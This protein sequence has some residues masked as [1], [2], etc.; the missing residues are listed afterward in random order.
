MSPQPGVSSPKPNKE[1]TH[2]NVAEPLQ[3]DD[4]AGRFNS[5]SLTYHRTCQSLEVNQSTVR[6]QQH[7]TRR[8]PPSKAQKQHDILYFEK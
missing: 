8:P 2:A 3:P 4:V 1:V 6:R 7:H 5:C